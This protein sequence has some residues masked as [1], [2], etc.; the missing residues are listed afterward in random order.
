[1]KK[2]LPRHIETSVFLSGDFGKFSHRL[3][4]LFLPISLLPVF[5]PNSRR[6]PSMPIPFFRNTMN[7]QFDGSILDKNLTEENSISETIFLFS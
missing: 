5:L 7:L 6:I 1:M 4:C 3:P 2:R